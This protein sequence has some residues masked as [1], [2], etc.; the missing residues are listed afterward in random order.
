METLVGSVDP[1]QGDLGARVI[2]RFRTIHQQTHH[3]V[4]QLFAAPSLE[5]QCGVRQCAIS[6]YDSIVMLFFSK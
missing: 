5:S 1:A 4:E 2:N 3:G 6:M